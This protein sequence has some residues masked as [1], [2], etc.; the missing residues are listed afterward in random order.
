VSGH[1]WYI[2]SVSDPDYTRGY[3]PRPDPAL[4]S[5]ENRKPRL[6]VLHRARI[7]G[8]ALPADLDPGASRVLEDA[9]LE[10]LRSDRTL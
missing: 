5:R 6:K 8:Y 10:R 2:Q 4:T 1:I 9:D 3:V 7:G